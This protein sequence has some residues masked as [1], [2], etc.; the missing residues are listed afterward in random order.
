MVGI[1]RQGN[2]IG[3]TAWFDRAPKEATELQTILIKLPWTI[4]LLASAIKA[5]KWAVIKAN[6]NPQEKKPRNSI[7]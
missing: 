6:W 1:R 4:G 5:G 3:A 2:C 7:V